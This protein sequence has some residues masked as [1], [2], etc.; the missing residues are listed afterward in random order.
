MDSDS[1]PEMFP[2]DPESQEN[3]LNPFNY[4]DPLMTSSLSHA[5]ATGNFD[6]VKSLIKSGKKVNN[7]DNNG[8]LPL[9]LAVLADRVEIVNL[10]LPDSDINF[11]NYGG[12]TPLLLSLLHK[13]S[14]CII[15]TL[16][17][18]GADIFT[19][20]NMKET[21]LHMSVRSPLTNVTEE[22][23]KRGA[24]I[25]AQDDNLY[26]PL[27]QAVQCNNVNAV[28]LLLY[29]NADVSLRCLHNLTPFMY[30]VNNDDGYEI[31]K[32]LFDYYDDFTS[33]TCDGY[34]PLLLAANSKNPLAIELV[35]YG[36][37]VN[38]YTPDGCTSLYLSLF[39]EDAELFKEIWSR[40]DYSKILRYNSRFVHGLLTNKT[41]SAAS[42]L[43]CIYLI[44]NSELVEDIIGLT[45]LT[46][47][48]HSRSCIS[49]YNLFRAFYLRDIKLDDRLTILYIF[50]TLGYNVTLCDITLIYYLYGYKHELEILIHHY[51]DLDNERFT[52]KCHPLP[53]F[54]FGLESS[55]STK[56]I[57]DLIDNQIKTMN[58]YA[59]KQI[60][61]LMILKSFTYFSIP[62]IEKQYLLNQICFT[63]RGVLEAILK[64][65]EVP[66]LIEIC[67]NNVR[68]YLKNTCRVKKPY[69]FHN[70][71]KRLQVSQV[72]KDILLFKKPLY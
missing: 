23:I 9:H 22:L 12:F 26:T 54:I 21:V 2:Y 6:E 72:I 31:A 64:I 33:T 1:E 20:N 48:R 14:E 67:R 57:A 58:F 40:I 55:Y 30:A 61:E 51:D 70:I 47:E 41:F 62:Y 49:L 32:I 15:M 56:F 65:P 3:L 13:K 50:L 35:K 19:K 39:F 4:Q 18:A 69:Q 68:F 52:L 71:V 27:I 63:N 45:V 11:K 36:V 42:W 16:V 37:D 43:E 66:S 8:N 44:L 28:C 29:Y 25:N 10:L 60:V 7:P 38:F 34:T 24:D 59:D 46:V 5:I 17:E 53:T